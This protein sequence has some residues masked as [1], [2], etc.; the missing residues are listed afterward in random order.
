MDKIQTLGAE[1]AAAEAQMLVQENRVAQAKA[2]ASQGV[3][4]AKKMEKATGGF[5]ALLLHEMLKAMWSTVQTTG[6][7]GEDSNQAQIYRDM[8]NQAISDSIAEG[9]GI[10]VKQ[11]LKKELLKMPKGAS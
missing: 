3:N 2:L 6:L 9:K 1:N 11:F 10:G 8:L 5:E 7:M 4:D